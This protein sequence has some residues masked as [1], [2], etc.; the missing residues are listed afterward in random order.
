MPGDKDTATALQKK[1]YGNPQG[2]AQHLVNIC[3]NSVNVVREVFLLLD[4]FSTLDVGC[5]FLNL[6]PTATLLKMVK[7]KIGKAFGAELLIWLSTLRHNSS[8]G[9]C[10]RVDFVIELK[11]LKDAVDNSNPQDD[12][13]NPYYTIDAGIVL[14]ADA[15]AIIDKI[16]PLYFAKVGKKFNV[17][18]GTRDAR[19][20]ANAM[21]GVI[22]AG[23]TN[24]PKY[25]NR[26]AVGEILDAYRKA[27]AAGSSRDG[28][29]Q[30]MAQVIQ[31]QIDTRGYYISPHLRAGAI[32]ISVKGDTGVPAMLKAEQEIMIK[33]AK[34]VITQGDAFYENEP[35]HIHI[36]F[37]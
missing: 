25:P 18:S 4:N 1:F 33:I 9:V 36:Q 19:R 28:I 22:E 6:L 30:A 16:A 12:G 21:L 27:K 37:K 32:D 26:Q 23:G 7:S 11:R 13:E 14:E 31:N 5:R 35:P 10:P 17:N 34:S 8:E 2:L 20:Q 15:L 3:L 24:L 29:V